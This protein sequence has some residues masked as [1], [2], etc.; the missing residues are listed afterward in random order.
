MPPTIVLIHGAFA[1]SASW[2]R[3]I[4]LLPADQAVIAAPNPLRGLAAG[5]ESVSDLVRTIDGPILLVAHSYGGAVMSAISSRSSAA[6]SPVRAAAA[7]VLSRR[8]RSA[9]PARRR[10][11]PRRYARASNQLPRIRLAEPEHVGDPAV[12]VVERLA[13]DVGRPLGRG[14]LLEQREQRVRDRL[15]LLHDPRRIVDE[16]DRV[17]RQRSDGDLATHAGRMPDGQREPRGHRHEE[18]GR[19]ADRVPVGPLPADPR[20]LH[21]VV[22]FAG[23]AEHR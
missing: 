2:D 9:A 5:A 22:G 3:V 13:Q 21:D 16:I 11:P 12:G 20:V 14:Q 8:W 7:N 6:R 23:A 15:A 1:D 18:P 4:D 10:R 17:G 19:I